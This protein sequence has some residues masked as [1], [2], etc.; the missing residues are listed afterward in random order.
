MRRS[1]SRHIV[2]MSSETTPG[3]HMDLHRGSGAWLSMTMASEWK[4]IFFNLKLQPPHIGGAQHKYRC[5]ADLHLSWRWRVELARFGD[6]RQRRN[7]ACAG[8]TVF[9]HT[10]E[11]WID[12]MI[13]NCD[14]QCHIALAQKTALAADA[15]DA[16]ALGG[17]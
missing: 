10:L 6:R 11:Q 17:K 3:N 7:V 16:Q 8:I 15:R 5:T 4:G 9:A 12:L 13:L 14:Q 1:R 2:M